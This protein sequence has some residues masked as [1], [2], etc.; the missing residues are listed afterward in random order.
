R[1]S[2]IEVVR[3][4][5]FGNETAALKVDDYYRVHQTQYSIAPSLVARSG[6]VRFSIGPLLKFAH[7]AFT[8][9]T[10]VDS[11]RPYGSADFVQVGA[12]AQFRVD[13]RR[14]E[15]HTSELQSRGHL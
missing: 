6:R 9:G 13:A 2:G 11:M 3:F 14:S 7:T 12:Q 10:L 5:G 4:Y 1:A 8:S 15:E